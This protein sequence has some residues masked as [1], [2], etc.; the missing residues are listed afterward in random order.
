MLHDIWCTTGAV[1]IH[2]A[3]VEDVQDEFKLQMEFKA[4]L[5]WFGRF[6]PKGWDLLWYRTADY[7]TN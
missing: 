7:P 5:G 6:P 1:M 2:V 4:K 3:R